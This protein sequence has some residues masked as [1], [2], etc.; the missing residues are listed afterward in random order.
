MGIFQ[1]IKQEVSPQEC[2][3]KYLGSP[4]KKGTTAFWLSPFSHEKTPSLA[5]NN[6]KG[7]HDFSTNQHYDVIDFTAKLYGVS[8]LDAAKIIIRDFGLNCQDEAIDTAELEN[9]KKKRE[10]HLLQKEQE[11]TLINDTFDKL[12]KL[13]KIFDGLLQVV[14]DK[15][16]FEFQFIRFNLDFMDRYSGLMIDRCYE[17]Q[18]KIAENIDRYYMAE[19]EEFQKFIATMEN[20]R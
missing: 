7:V 5:A 18:L 20:Q 9:R 17:D 3:I 12:C 13:Y 6:E 8:P 10:L 16:S 2:C 19:W 15:A 11:K 14:E 1:E 4:V